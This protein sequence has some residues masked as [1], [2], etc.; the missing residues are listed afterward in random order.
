MPVFVPVKRQDL[1]RCLRQLGFEGPYAG[2]R[3]QYLIR[4]EIK[5]ALPNPHQG[6]ISRDLLSRMLRQGGS[7]EKSGRSFEAV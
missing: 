6:D 4:G 1:I 2:G 3:H 5:L 7:A